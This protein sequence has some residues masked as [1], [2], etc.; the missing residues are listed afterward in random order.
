MYHYSQRDKLSLEM[1]DR[2]YIFAHT[3]NVIC[4]L[5]KNAVPV[6]KIQPFQFVLY[7]LQ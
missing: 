2:D 7:P 5:P 3:I 6:W 1:E 4:E